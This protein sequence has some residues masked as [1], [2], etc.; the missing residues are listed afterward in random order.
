MHSAQL[1]QKH[2]GSIVPRNLIE[3]DVSDWLL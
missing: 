2:M 1:A 3:A